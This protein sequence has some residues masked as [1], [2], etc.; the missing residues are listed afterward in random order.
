MKITFA[1]FDSVSI[2][3]GGALVQV[4]ET[5]RE[6]EALGISVSL[7]DRWKPFSPAETDLVHI[8]AAR[9]STFQMAMTM[10]LLVVP[11]VT[12]SIFFTQHSASVIRTA[13]RVEKLLKRLRA[14]IRTD[15]GYTRQICEW[16][17]A[18]LP[19]THDEAA[20]IHDGM[21]IPAEKIT[22]I[23]NGVDRRFENADP[24]LFIKT[25][26]VKDFILNVGHIGPG[27]KN[28][29]GLIRAL[30]TIDHPAVIIGRITADAASAACV[31]AAAKNKNI[32][33]IPG[34][35]N[36]SKMLASAY[37]ACD[38]FV[39]PSLFET[40]GIAALE[41]GLAGAKVVITPHG[42]TRDYFGS[43]AHYAEPHSVESIRNAITLALSEPKTT[44]LRDH[45]KREFLWS[46]VAQKTA[47]V[48]K[49]ILSQRSNRA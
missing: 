39:L 16:S 20:L 44:A 29:L 11:V 17:E 27:R 49:R 34:L 25:Y 23:P 26:G 42:G 41:A 46:T 43:M 3:H 1:C 4:R 30:E 8:F 2:D 45:I 7:F 9:Y 13:L 10:K 38:T 35:S 48:Y 18:V 14:G 40:P 6:L 36:D 32:L 31:S 21:G 5:K 22:V 15:Y 37:A 24:G 28:V 33:L 47:E 19:N 12:S